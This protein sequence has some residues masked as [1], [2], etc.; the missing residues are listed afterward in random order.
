MAKFREDPFVLYTLETLLEK[1][2]LGHVRVRKHGD[3]LILE[4]GPKSDPVRH[5]RMRRD[6]Q[7][8]YLLDIATHTGRWQRVPTIRAPAKQVLETV[9]DQFPWVLTPIA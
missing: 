7:Q 9:I 8:W 5:L 4:S 3:L 1:H 6:T 2:G